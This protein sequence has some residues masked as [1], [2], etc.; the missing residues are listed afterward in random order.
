VSWAIVVGIDRYWS[1][2]A[3]LGG[4]VRD[5]LRLREWLLDPAGG[6]VEPDK[7]VLLLS[8]RPGQEPAGVQFA[9]ATKDNIVVA[10]NDVIQASGGEGER[11]WF[12]FAGHGLTARVASR[13]ESALVAADFNAVNTDN[14]IALRSLWEF[15]ETTQFADQFFF[16]DAC[17]NIPWENR[18]FEIGR[19]TLP[20]SRD[21]G[22]PPVQQFI[23]YATSP[24]LK[25][26]EIREFGNERGAFTD[27]LLAGLRGDGRAKAWS[28]E[29]KGYEV[30]WERLVDYVKERLEAERRKIVQG[31]E[32]ALLQIPQDAG[33][34]GVA[35]RDRDPA[36][37]AFPE[38]AF[39][40][41]RLDVLLD[42]NAVV[43]VARV[44]VLDGVGD[45]AGEQTQLTGLPVAFE[46]PPKTYIVRAQAPAYAEGRAEGPVELYEPIEETVKLAPCEPSEAPP[47]AAGNGP[48]QAAR[49][50]AETS[51]PLA[52]VELLDEAGQLVA[53]EP[54]KLEVPNLPP[55]FYR[56][57]AA[58]PEKVGRE[59]RVHMAG[60]DDEPLK[61]RL[62]RPA[63]A[64]RELVEA[65][66]GR[67]EPDNAVVVSDAIGPLGAPQPATL[68]TLAAGAA[69]DADPARFGEPLGRLGLRRF[70][71]LLPAGA[72]AGVAAFIAAPRAPKSL[73]RTHVRLW[74][75]AEDVPA[76]SAVPTRATEWLGASVAAA[77]P[78]SHWLSVEPPRG[79]PIVFALAVLP[80]RLTVVIV[81]FDGE[82]LRT[83]QY[84]P[85]LEPSGSSEPSALRAAEHLQRLLLAG[86]LDG[87][88]PLAAAAA[89]AAADDPLRGCLGGY[90]LLRLGLAGELASAAAALVAGAPQLSDAHVLAGEHAAA[91]GRRDDAARAFAAAAE[92]APPIFGEGLT[93]LLEG[94]R[95][96]E[97]EHARAALVEELFTRHVS[98][99]MWSVFTPPRLEPGAPLRITT[100]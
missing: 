93:R 27:A 62:P 67:V 30:R 14:S 20:R 97:L 63:R 57:R 89:A 33:G 84:L 43:P 73:E 99:S 82:T 81:H 75:S 7:V 15:F 29:R 72:Q 8:P 41:E 21:P 5:A 48:A 31:P 3:S 42:P 55:G 83:F 94:L 11:L 80:G 74:P 10:V 78:G 17:R 58:T 56:A 49:F 25:A 35:G 68:V 91:A 9:E 87:A 79:D 59:R 51:D 23:L 53:V 45:V 88:Q 16:V 76:E 71:E 92:A 66:A 52:I 95:A 32:G 4:A 38:T 40:A 2:A 22:L 85:T 6:G 86:R 24:G 36:L 26:T 19:W 77:T 44:R 13:D 46:L 47:D 65:I 37:A 61:L 70:R 1:D 90:T 69:L 39:S 18:E 98:G 100:S 60:E 54:G 34:R 50:R 28:W 96:F 12:F 64:V